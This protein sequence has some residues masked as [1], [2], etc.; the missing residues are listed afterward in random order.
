M[1]NLLEKGY[2]YVRRFVLQRDTLFSSPQTPQQQRFSPEQR[3]APPYYRQEPA[4]PQQGNMVPRQEYPQ[5][6]YAQQGDWQRGGM[7]PWVAGGLGALGGGLAG[8]GLGQAVGEMQQDANGDYRPT[9]DHSNAADSGL[10]DAGFG[11]M[12]SGGGG[13]GGE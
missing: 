9:D 5:Q 7:N 3:Y 12:D 2:S 4:Y 1:R 10:A 6:R 8:Y 11:D 13:F